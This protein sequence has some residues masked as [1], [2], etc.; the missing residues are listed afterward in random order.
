MCHTIRCC[1]GLSNPN[2]LTTQRSSSKEKENKRMMQILFFLTQQIL[3]LLIFYLLFT[4]RHELLGVL[5]NLVRPLI[6][7]RCKLHRGKIANGTITILSIFDVFIYVEEML[8]KLV[9][10]WDP[11]RAYITLMKDEGRHSTIS[12]EDHSLEKSFTMVQSS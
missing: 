9:S 10:A 1:I 7:A 5:Q 3:I 8:R 6:F 4:G 11:Q 2:W 12:I